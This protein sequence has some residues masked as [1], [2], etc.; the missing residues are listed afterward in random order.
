MFLL[1]FSISHLQYLNSVLACTLTLDLTLTRALILALSLT[2]T[3]TRLLTLA[4]T[5]TVLSRSA[6]STPA[7][8]ATPLPSP[9]LPPTTTA[10]K[11]KRATGQ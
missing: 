2:L 10:P 11:L 4:L 7:A 3:L 8:K 6:I 1:L 9:R 5:H